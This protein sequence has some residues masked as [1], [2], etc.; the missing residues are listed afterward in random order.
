MTSTPS[1]WTRETRDRWFYGA[2]FASFLSLVWLFSGYAAVLLFACVFTVV[3]WPVFER[4]LSLTGGRRGVAAVATVSL[5]AVVVLGP[6]GFLAYAF[7]IEAVAVVQAGIDLVKSGAAEEWLAQGMLEPRILRIRQWLEPML[8]E[9]RGTLESLLGPLRAGALG[10]LNAIGKALPSLLNAIVG[11]GINA[12]IFLFTTVSLFMEG[13]RV[14]DLIRNLSPMDD[15]YEDRLIGVFR[16]FARN[17]VVGSLAT[18]AI[19]GVVATLGYWIAGADRVL[20]LGILTSVFG[21]VPMVGTLVVWLPTAIYVAVQHGPEWGVFVAVWSLVFTG[22]VDNLLKPLFLRGSSDIHPLLIFL[23]VFGGLGTMGLPG[24]LM[25]PMCV[26]FF[27]ALYQIYSEDYLGI[28]PPPVPPA[29][30]G[31]FARLLAWARPP[32]APSSPVPE[33]ARVEHKPRSDA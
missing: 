10:A 4:V 32:R 14:L 5:L 15:A 6:L 20:F 19:Q 24:L 23:S 17:L 8:P 26:A 27:L 31:P 18:S 12:V 7:A 11:G 3:T 28:P 1:P 13:P 21:F 33:L 2:L 16:E 29:V 22:T 25:G 9:G 30:P